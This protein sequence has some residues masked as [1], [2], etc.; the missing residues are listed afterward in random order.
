[1][2]YTW[3]S[4]V[5]EGLMVQRVGPLVRLVFELNAMAAVVLS[6]RAI[7]AVGRIG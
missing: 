7:D 3:Q 1:L 4:V 6:K 2:K 5:K